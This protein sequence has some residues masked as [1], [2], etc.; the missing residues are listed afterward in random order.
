MSD[1]LF[2]LV[3][4]M[5]IEFSGN[6]KQIDQRFSAMDQRIGDVEKGQKKLELLIENEVLDKIRTLYDDRA[7]MKESLT[8]INLKLD[9][10]NNVAEDHELR[11]K[12]LE[13]GKKAI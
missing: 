7:E 8:S 13:A 11:I 12:V 10:L 5:Y 9:N 1:K 6:F 2:D 4:K 3:E